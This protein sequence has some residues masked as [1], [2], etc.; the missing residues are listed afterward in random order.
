MIPTSR[1]ILMLDEDGYGVVTGRIKDIIIRGGE[2]IQPQEIEYFLESH[3]S[4]VQAQV[5][6]RFYK[7][8]EGLKKKKL[9]SLFIFFFKVF[10]IPNDR[11]GEVV[12]AAIKITKGSIIDE[13]SVMNY[14]IGNVIRTINIAI[15]SDDSISY[16][17]RINYIY[18]CRSQD[19]K[20][21]NT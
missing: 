18:L 16:F 19:S 4:I 7:Y 11:L 15:V 14:C 2:N 5:C 12:C 1:D 3:P 17:S 6:A 10:G 13:E 21:R 8:Y 9:F 20:F